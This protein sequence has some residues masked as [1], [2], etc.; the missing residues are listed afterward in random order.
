MQ[1]RVQLAAAARDAVQLG[2][3]VAGGVE[4][5]E[6]D[7]APPVDG[8]R[9]REGQVVEADGALPQVD[10]DGD[11]AVHEREVEPRREAGRVAGGAEAEEAR[12]R[13]V[14]RRRDGRHRRREVDGAAEAERR[15]LARQAA[16]ELGAERVL[17]AV[18][19]G[20]E[21][22]VLVAHHRR[23]VAK[24]AVGR[25][26]VVRGE[27]RREAERQ[28]LRDAV[29]HHE[30]VAQPA[31]AHARVDVGRSRHGPLPRERVAG[32]VHV[33]EVDDEAAA[34]GQVVRQERRVAAVED[35]VARQRA[36]REVRHPPPVAEPTAVGEVVEVAREDA[37]LVV[38]PPHR[39]DCRH[40]RGHHE[41]VRLARVGDDLARLDEPRVQR[42]LHREGAL[43]VVARAEAAVL[44]RRV[45]QQARASTRAAPL[46]AGRALGLADTVVL[47]MVVPLRPQHLLDDRQ[48]LAAVVGAG[49]PVV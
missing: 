26:V 29:R 17:A 30:V 25:A 8:A 44:A 20:V 22:P 15:R 37:A 1:P 7:G 13:R 16:R 27:P 14:R 28:P 10:E 48:V 23:T 47:E 49:P 32:V 40:E 45:G 3:E 6:E 31:L 2:E 19:V 4:A 11:A 21:Q 46:G 5:A 24:G 41:G 33:A 43:V 35:E 12:H 36:R 18:E 42:Q 34:V 39:H 38:A 9:E